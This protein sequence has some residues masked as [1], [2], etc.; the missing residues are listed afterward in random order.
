MLSPFLRGSPEIQPGLAEFRYRG[1]SAPE[2]CAFGHLDRR[3][4]LGYLAKSFRLR[5]ES[6]LL[7][8]W[9]PRRLWNC[10]AGSFFAFSAPAVLAVDARAQDVAPGAAA[11]QSIQSSFDAPPDHGLPLGDWMLYPS[12]FLGVTWN[13]NYFV[14]PTNRRD[15]TGFR[16]RPAIEALRDDGIHRT[17]LFASADLQV[18]PGLGGVYQIAPATFTRGERQTVGAHV[19]GLHVWRPTNDLEITFLADYSRQSGLFGTDFGASAWRAS[20]P[21][22]APISSAGGHV[23][24]VTGL[25]AVEKTFDGVFFLRAA[26]RAQLLDFD[27]PAPLLAPGT[28]AARSG[29]GYTLSLR[30]GAW[31]SPLLYVFAEPSA[32]LRRYR[33]SAFDSNGYQVVAGVGSDLIGL[34]RGEIYAGYGRQHAL[35]SAL[36]AVE[37]PLF[38]ARL[39]WFPTRD[40]VF[41]ATAEHRLSGAAATALAATATTRTTFARLQ[42]DYAA[43]RW[44]TLFARGGYGRT[45][46]TGLGRRDDNWTVGAGLNYTFWRNV[47]LTLEYQHSRLSARGPALAAPFLSWSGRRQNILSAGL[48]YRY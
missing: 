16:V 44:L 43:A 8:F 22:F 11:R 5:A 33:A 34:M 26:A 9:R 14:T 4:C 25:V 27:D 6:R 38:G 1:V 31:V 13:D 46:W 15:A 36:P 20:T 41:T 32:D 45:D 12:L 17:S 21:S 42:V 24:Q 7:R 40:L 29:V 30:A 28:V 48:T 10:I 37:S 2:D 18:Y 39:S 23:D 35:S 47:A 19:G 3:A